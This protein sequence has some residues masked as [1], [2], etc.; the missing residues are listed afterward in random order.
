M[1][2]KNSRERISAVRHET[3]TI[4]IF[5]IIM[6]KLSSTTVCLILLLPSSALLAAERQSVDGDVSFTIPDPSLY[7]RMETTQPTVARWEAK[8]GRINFLIKRK[9][10]QPSVQVSQSDLERDLLTEI[11]LTVQNGKILNSTAQ[12]QD[13]YDFFSI[14]GQGKNGNTTIYFTQKIVAHEEKNYLVIAVAVGIGTDTRT[15]HDAIAFFNSIK[16]TS[17]QKT[18]KTEQ[19]VRT[20]PLQQSENFSS[21]RDADLDGN[22]IGRIALRIFILVVVTVLGGKKCRD[23]LRTEKSGDAKKSW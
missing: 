17:L 4:H 15:N 9:G 8:D 3:L 7:D 19:T 2:A 12:K 20:T 11:N 21:Q 14:T 5:R 6:C 18:E 1:V 16:V 10:L 13:G 23:N 22:F